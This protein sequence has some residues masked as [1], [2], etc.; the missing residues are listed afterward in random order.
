VSAPNWRLGIDIGATKTLGVVVDEAGRVVAECR[1]PTSAG[2]GGV[3]ATAAA[4]V[5][6]LRAEIEWDGAPDAWSVGVGVPGLVDTGTG[7]VK[8]AVNLGLDGE[9]LPLRD[10]V[11]ARLRL[12]VVVDNDVNA[13]ALGASALLPVGPAPP[14]LVYLSLGTGLAAGLVLGGRVRRGVHGAAGE[15]GHV[16]VDPNGPRCGCGQRGCLETRASGA[17][18]AAAWPTPDGEPAAV[19]LFRAAARGDRRAVELRDGFAD[20]IAEAVRLLCL[21]VDA[22]AVVLG[23][24]VAQLGEPLRDAVADALRRQARVSGFLTSLGLADRLRLVPAGFPVAAVGAALLGRPP[25]PV[26]AG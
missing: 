13:A 3:V 15:I 6:R 26:E 18:V 19:S 10:L 21:A 22:D 20:A 12:P 4:V 2:A 24:G 23:G 5:A 17:A 25:L 7:R 9:W 16:P 11:A 14:D 8:H 1:E